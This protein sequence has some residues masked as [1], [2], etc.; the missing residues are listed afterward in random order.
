MTVDFFN[1]VEFFKDLTKEAQTEISK[2][3]DMRTYA[4]DSIIVDEGSIGATLYIIGDGIVQVMK[5]KNEGA[6]KTLA[7]LH[8][9]DIFGELSLIDEA[10]RSATVKAVT[11]VTVYQFS[12]ENFAKIREENPE[13]YFNIYE[14]V[15]REICKRLRRM[16]MEFLGLSTGRTII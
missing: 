10:P 11:D 8:S 4:R 12:K 2:K 15:S 1:K 16:N 7:I 14:N 9:G 6:F 3:L 5:S 13:V